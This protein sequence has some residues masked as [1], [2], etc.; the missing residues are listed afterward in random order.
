VR[1]RRCAPGRIVRP[2]GCGLTMAVVA[3][4]PMLVGAHPARAASVC[5]TPVA[6][7]ALFAGTPLAQ[8]ALAPERVWPTTTGQGVTVAVLDTGVDTTNPQLAGAVA[9]GWDMVTGTV[10]GTLDCSGH[11]TAMASL[12]AARPASDTGLRGLAPG[13]RVLPIRVSEQASGPGAA[14]VPAGVLAD[15]IERAT[16]AGAGVITV[17]LPSAGDTPQLAAA[18]AYAR[19]HDVLLV[20]NAAAVSAGTAAAD[21]GTTG[22]TTASGDAVYPAAYPNVLG[23]AGVD[24]NGVRLPD[25]STGPSA[26]I[27]APGENA[28][29]ARPGRGADLIRG[30][31]DVATAVVGATVALVRAAYPDLTADEVVSRV[32]AT[33]DPV[34]DIVGSSS[35]RRMIDLDR[36][37]TEVPAVQRPRALPSLPKP[38][39]DAV[40]RQRRAHWSS[41][42]REAINGGLILVSALVAVAAL[43][44]AGAL[45]RRRDSLAE[46]GGVAGHPWPPSGASP[47]PVGDDG[48]D[49]EPD[50]DD[51]TEQFF[52]VPTVRRVG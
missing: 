1:T 27:V 45:I 46:S 51:H 47:D 43:I 34:P 16:D 48:P 14:A 49:R 42:S 31:S 4:A 8:V 30:G 24:V 32:L 35:A 3:V 21:T 2:V 22:D 33:A 37:V 40:Q 25:A 29:G 9:T 39:D 23:V 28:V 11:G 44:G 19:D 50:D 52:T 15:A 12:I 18:V 17:T 26:D 7:G 5:P 6:P 10:G 36:A 38:A 20:A 13:A 41:L